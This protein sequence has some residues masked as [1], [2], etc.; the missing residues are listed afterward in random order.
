M[1]GIRLHRTGTKLG[2]VLLQMQQRFP[3][4]V[5][6]LQVFCRLLPSGMRA[7]FEF[8]DRTW[9]RDDVWKVLDDSGAAFVLPD[10]PGLVVP[11]VVCGGW[12]YVRFHQGMRA[13]PDY[14]R[15]KLRKW[16]IG[17]AHV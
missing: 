1:Y 4:D 13:K 17:R 3:V 14:P 6:R 5:D 2:P 9:E 7:A 12:S 11:D 16:E 8:R 10:R 15:A